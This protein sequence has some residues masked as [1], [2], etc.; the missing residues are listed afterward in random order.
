MSK[1]IPL[2]V[3]KKGVLS[4]WVLVDSLC[5]SIEIVPFEFDLSRP[6]RSYLALIGK[7]R[8]HSIIHIAD[9]GL[10]WLVFILP[11]IKILTVHGADRHVL[12][13]G[14]EPLS[15]PVYFTL[16]WFSSLFARIITVSQSA[17]KEI[18]SAYHF[19]SHKIEVIYHGVPRGFEPVSPGSSALVQF[20]N[21]YSVKKPFFLHVSSGLRKKNFD[22]VLS[23]FKQVSE[24]HPEVKLVIA[25]PG[26]KQYDRIKAVLVDQHKIKVLVGLQRAEL[27]LLYSLALALVFPSLHESYGRPLTE[28]MACGCPVI[29]ANV[30]AMPEIAGDAGI[31]VDPYNIKEIA[32][33]MNRVLTDNNL[34]GLLRARGL[35]RAAEFSLSSQ[36]D[37]HV[38]LYDSIAKGNYAAK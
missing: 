3:F 25:L 19:P 23:A 15:L 32:G 34:V 36:I 2:I 7:A 24:A 17:K 6:L 16:R 30:F 35:K 4:T 8:K 28:A 27:S 13:A 5:S 37:R 21:K 9:Q 10:A 12:K 38:A 1:Q 29:T 18:M 31:L 20:S 14:T 11:G 22:R 33:A 26:Q